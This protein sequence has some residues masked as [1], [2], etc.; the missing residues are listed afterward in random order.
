MNI[1]AIF[2]TLLFVALIALVVR[3][4]DPFQTVITADEIVERG[5]DNLDELLASVQGLYL[6]HNRN[7][8]QIGI[9]GISSAGGNNQRVQV[10][11]DGVPLNNPMTGQAP[12]GY[13]LRG[14]AME[15][16][17][18]VTITRAPSPVLQ[19]NNAMLGVIRITTKKRDKGL[20]LNFDTGSFG[21]LDGGLALS[22][23]IGKTQIG[24][25]GRLARING[26]EVY[27]PDDSTP[28]S[29][30]ERFSGLGL[31]VERGKFSFQAYYNQ[32]AES[33]AGLSSGRNPISV[34]LSQYRIIPYPVQGTTGFFKE[35]VDLPGSFNESH[36]FSE[37]RFST[38]IGEKQSAE[39]RLFLNYATY[40]ELLA[41]RDTEEDTLFAST[42]EYD[43]AHL[44]SALWSGLSYKHA[45]QLGDRHRLQAGADLVGAPILEFDSHTGAVSQTFAE[46]G[47]VYDTI[48]S[49]FS[50]ELLDYL[51]S[52]HV[53][54]FESFAYWTFSLYAFH[55]FQLS[56]QLAFSGG[57]RVDVNSQTGPVVAPE[58]NVLYTPTSGKTALRLGYSN[59]Y[60]LP[61]ILETAVMAPGQALPNPDLLAEKVHNFELG[62]AQQINEHFNLNLSLYHRRLDD[63]IQGDELTNRLQNQ[64]D[65]VL[66]ATGLD[67]GLSVGPPKGI[68]TYFNYNFQFARRNEVNMPSPLCKFGVTIPFLR[69]FTLFTEGQYEGARLTFTGRQTLPFFLMNANLLIRPQLPESSRLSGVFKAMNFAFRVYNI[70]DE[71]YQHP[72][73]GLYRPGLI[74]QNGRTWQAQWTL[75]F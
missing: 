28:D 32:R 44:Q 20:R 60:R 69:H 51:E 7:A 9:R 75:E 34:D 74:P 12:S 18:S 55:D 6:T 14:I 54:F 65:S 10:L 16:I 63:L 49:G 73:E 27:L 26:P 23:S 66:Q 72:A 11:I 42:V 40:D 41:F 3:A 50:D 31:R 52:K 43:E 38:P 62:W 45:F 56:S 59:G 15:D 48:T 61:G 67:A 37:M 25:M 71:F 68:R 70:W 30:E 36:I 46:A 5:Y 2:V 19:G 13:D 22:G 8:T 39:V 53:E 47:F 17:E 33:T 57:A 1:K 64:A 58:L 35:S 24:L 4:Q 29:E 21:E